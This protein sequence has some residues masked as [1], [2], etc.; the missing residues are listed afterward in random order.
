M[1]SQEVVWG[2][3]QA[4]SGGWCVSLCGVIS[5]VSVFVGLVSTGDGGRGGGIS[6]QKLCCWI[7]GDCCQITGQ[8][9]LANQSAFSEPVMC[10]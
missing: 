1:G 4:Q 3:W 2:G 6:W 9:L 10:V 7:R 8:T 5:V